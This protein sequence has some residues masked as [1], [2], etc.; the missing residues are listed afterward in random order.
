MSESDETDV[1]PYE[2]AVVYARLTSA[3]TITDL[4]ATLLDL[5]QPAVVTVDDWGG[6]Q[7]AQVLLPLDENEQ[8]L[9]VEID[10]PTFRWRPQPVSTLAHV[11]ARDLATE[12]VCGEDVYGRDGA[13]SP[14]SDLTVVP[15]DAEAIVWFS[16]LDAPE[17]V[18]IVARTAGGPLAWAKVDGG[19]VISDL[20]SPQATLDSGAWAIESEVVLWTS[21][22]ARGAGIFFRK[23]P[24]FHVWQESPTVVDPTKPWH[25]DG[26]G[27]T[28]AEYSVPLPSH[29][30]EDVWSRRFKLDAG[31]A[32]RLRILFRQLE[33]T[34]ETFTLL[35][36]ILGI[37]PVVAEVAEGVTHFSELDDVVIVEPMTGLQAF[38]KSMAAEVAKPTDS[39]WRRLRARHPRWSMAIVI[40]VEV[41]AV[42]FLLVN[43]IDG[44]YWGMLLAAV[45]AAVWTRELFLRQPHDPLSREELLAREE[46]RKPSS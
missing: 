8:S 17:L 15:G 3:A 30:E 9:S 22:T 7:W 14:A 31:R 42:G 33:P 2:T 37:G 1:F 36:D 41:F 13:A 19:C 29:Y 46:D 5:R 12:V 27:L 10:S 44:D 6:E 35:T 24:Y 34:A 28:V 23:E 16:K 11:L 25:R 21:G 39:W 4:T 45:V 38:K 32:E 26:D 43:L 18:G 20:V 40:A